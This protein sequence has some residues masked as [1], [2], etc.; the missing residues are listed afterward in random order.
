MNLTTL[1]NQL[2]RYRMA[3]PDVIEHAQNAAGAGRFVPQKQNEFL[4]VAM[5]NCCRRLKAISD[6]KYLTAWVDCDCVCVC[7]C[8]ARCV[9]GA[10]R[11]TGRVLNISVL[12]SVCQDLRHVYVSTDYIPSVFNVSK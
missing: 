1:E 8:G 6:V 5:T 3:D 2:A 7:V 9:Y 12:F 4:F 10:L 11:E